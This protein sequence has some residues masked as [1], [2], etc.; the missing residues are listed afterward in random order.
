[1]RHSSLGKETYALRSRTI[2]RVFTDAKGR[3]GMRYTPF[4]GL[5]RVSSL[6]RLKFATMNLKILPLPFFNPCI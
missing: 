6:V 2:E 1:M 3:H 5:T 4:R